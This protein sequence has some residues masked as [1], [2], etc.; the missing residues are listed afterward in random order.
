MP[1]AVRERHTPDGAVQC[2]LSP[3]IVS[4]QPS[5]PS[6]LFPHRDGGGGAG[7]QRR[8]THARRQVQVLNRTRRP[9]GASINR[10]V[11][12]ADEPATNRAVARQPASQW[13][14]GR[15]PAASGAAY[16]MASQPLPS[17]NVPSWEMRRRKRN[18]QEQTINFRPRRHL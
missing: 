3:C 9:S 13:K 12:R 5:V 4:I 11:N 14:A 15:E 7:C 1:V 17:G 16:R 6:P 8:G 10:F 18:W 2:R